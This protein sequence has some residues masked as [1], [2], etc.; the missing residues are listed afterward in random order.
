MTDYIADTTDVDMGALGLEGAN[1]DEP[2][3]GLPPSI[4]GTSGNDILAGTSGADVI[5]GLDGDDTLRGFFDDDRL[6]GGKGADVLYGKR[7]NDLLMAGNG[8]DTLYGGKGRDLLFGYDGD[9]VLDGGLGRDFLKEG[10]G[11]D[12]FV[13]SDNYGRDTIKDFENDIDTIQLDANLWGG[14]LSVAEMLGVF[15]TYDAAKGD[16]V[17]DFG[18]FNILRIKDETD[19]NVLLD[20]V[21]II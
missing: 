21:V 8:N 5:E 13:F 20:D 1:S 15:G 14:G 16:V 11:Q 10:A 19:V 4:V 18:G 12:T 17:L 7:G 9:D 6:F 3:P 2:L